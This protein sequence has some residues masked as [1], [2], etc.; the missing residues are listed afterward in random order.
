MAPTFLRDLEE[1]VPRAAAVLLAIAA[2]LALLMAVAAPVNHRPEL[3]RGPPDEHGH[4]SSAR[5]YVDHWMPPVVGARETLGSYSRDYGYSYVNDTDPCYFLA[6]KFAKVLSPIVDLDRGFRLFNVALLAALA[7]VCWLRPRAWPVFVPL[8]VTPQVWYIF[9]YFN[10]DALPLFLAVLVAWQICDPESGFNRF[11]DAPDWRRGWPAALAMGVLVGLLLLSKKNYLAFVALV[12]AALALTRFDRNTP[13]IVAGATL[14]GAAGYLGWLRIGGAAA[15]AI[16]AIAL[17]AASSVA[18]HRVETRA[19]RGR[20]VAKLAALMLLAGTVVAARY[21]WDIAQHGSLEAKQAAVGRMQEQLA[22]P[23]YKPSVIYSQEREKSYYGIE[24][25]ARG[26]PLAELFSPKWRWHS[27]SFATAT[28]SYGWIQFTAGE[29]YYA[30][31]VVGY[32]AIFAAYAW[33]AIRAGPVATTALALASIFSALVVAVALW[34]SWNN[35]FQAQGR[36][37]FPVLPMLG[38]GFFFARSRLPSRAFLAAVAFC[39]LLSL[40]S[41]VF[42][43]LVHVPGSF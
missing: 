27:L 14:L 39:F 6:G 10:S 1:R 21:G 15:L 42:I 36:Y 38:L 16:G 34:H 30:L 13:W 23:E 29:W 28:G 2:L 41:F 26:T 43:G 25:R 31:M 35:D 3:W 24:L 18:F 4:R 20:T 8:L 33:A 17:A 11:L 5:Y 9:S 32:L 37:L 7:A 40:Y 12:P 19:A 22:K